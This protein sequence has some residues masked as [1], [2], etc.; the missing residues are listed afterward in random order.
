MSNDK[1][2][3]LSSSDNHQLSAFLAEP[4]TE[5]KAGLVILQEIFGVTEHMKNL[6]RRYAEQG[7]RT[8]VPALFDRVAPDSVIPY[9][10][11]AKGRSL[12]E[13]CQPQAV[14]KDIQAAADLVRVDHKVAVIGYCWGG[15]YAYLSACELPISAATAYYGTRIIEQLSKKPR[16]PVQFHFGEEDPIITPGQVAQ[17]K[18]ANPTQPIYVYHGAGHAFSNADRPSYHNEASR[19]A[20]D[21]TLSFLQQIL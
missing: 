18:A 4:A 12:A 10:K 2:I 19:L 16:C 3:Q 8:I 13:Q 15:T 17:I 14:L 20:E 9:D 1:T 6:A 5:P 21:R 7:Y 11:A